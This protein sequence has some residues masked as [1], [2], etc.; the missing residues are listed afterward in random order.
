MTDRD[1]AGCGGPPCPRCEDYSAGYRAGKP[2]ALFEVSTRTIDHPRGCGCDLCPAVAERLRRCPG[3]ELWSHP[4]E[5]SVQEPCRGRSDR[6]GLPGG[7]D[8][9]LGFL[10]GI[11]LAEVELP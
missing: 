1:H 2:R 5:T 6:N 11:E 7:L 9:G 10:L 3:P 8:I 4:N